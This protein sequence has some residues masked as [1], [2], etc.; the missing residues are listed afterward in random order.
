MTFPY[1]NHGFSSEVRAEYTD[2][3]YSDADVSPYTF[4]GIALGNQSS[5]RYVVVCVHGVSDES[6]TAVSVGGEAL[7]VAVSEQNVFTVG[8]TV[9]IWIGAVPTGATGDIVVT[10]GA[11]AYVYGCSIGVYAL[12]GL[13]S[14]TPTDTDTD[15]FGAMSKTI[16]VLDGGVVVAAFLHS[17]EEFN[18]AVYTGITGVT[19]VYSE[20]E[21]T[22]ND[23]AGRDYLFDAVG[24]FDV[25]PVSG[26]VSVEVSLSDTPINAVMVLA[27]FR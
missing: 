14:A 12:G 1:C 13:N 7:A 4:S 25:F 6:P 9:S 22:G 21:D 8:A 5:D 20:F 23:Y 10:F 16:T 18:S 26:N 15:N 2:Y 19:E 17:N 3:A 11:S 24:A 27:A